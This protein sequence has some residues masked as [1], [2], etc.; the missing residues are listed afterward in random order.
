MIQYTFEYYSGGT[1]YLTIP[2][3]VTGVTLKC[4][5]GGG[6]GGETTGSTWTGGGGGGAFA[7]K[8]LS[9][10]PGGVLNITVGK[11]GISSGITNGENTVINYK[12]VDVC[13]A[14]YGE[15]VPFTG[16]TGGA[17]G[18]LFNCIGDITYNGGDGSSVT[19]S[20]GGSG[21]GGASDSGDGNDATPD[22]GGAYKSYGG[23]QGATSRKVPEGPDPQYDGGAFGGG[24]SGYSGPVDVE[25]SPGGNGGAGAA[26]ITYYQKENILL[27]IPTSF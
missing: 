17:G 10:S 19:G 14:A 8:Y 16:A 15:G 12:S 26:I 11:G 23:G 22:I 1:Y 20:G 5:G 13:L 25:Y 7:Q 21:G 4:W 27:N 24:G 3:G 6:A 2:F 18:S 9:V